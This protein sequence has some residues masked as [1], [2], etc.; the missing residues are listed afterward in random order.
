MVGARVASVTFERVTKIFDDRVRAVNGLTREVPDGKFMVLVGP[1]GCG[2]TTAL[3]MVAGLEGISE[4]EI[5]IGDT[6]RR[7]EE[8]RALRH[9]ARPSHHVRTTRQGRDDLDISRA[10]PK[11][12]AGD[13]TP[14][15][16]TTLGDR[17]WGQL[18]GRPRL[19]REAEDNREAP[20]HAA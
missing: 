17:P 4:G 6:G 3:R 2:K 14:P 19:L 12:Q 1:S 16:E 9:G 7:S 8:G 13:T 18:A 10:S 11:S 15:A 20:S 5:R